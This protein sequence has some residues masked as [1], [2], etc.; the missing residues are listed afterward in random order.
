M[1]QTTYFFSRILEMHSHQLIL[2]AARGVCPVCDTSFTNISFSTLIDLYSYCPNIL[3]VS[4][5]KITPSVNFAIEITKTFLSYVL[6][7]IL[8]TPMAI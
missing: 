8:L 1:A 5:S 4:A 7:Q 6:K 3:L 2:G